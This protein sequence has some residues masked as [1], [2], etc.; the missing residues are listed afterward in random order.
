MDK[1][2]EK[3]RKLREDKDRLILKNYELAQG[4]G[5]YRE[6]FRNLV[7]SSQGLL[8]ALQ[9][10][11]NIV[12]SEPVDDDAAGKIRDI[13]YRRLFSSFDEEESDNDHQSTQS[14]ISDLC[15][16]IW[17][18]FKKAEDDQAAERGKDYFSNEDGEIDYYMGKYVA[19][20]KIVESD[21]F[22]KLEG[23]LEKEESNGSV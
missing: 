13:C 5:V 14:A 9:D 23:L 4:L 10:I 16:Y 20:K 19:M 6:L 2:G 7:N 22:K 17:K 12:N 3:I 21:K 8:T 11:V 18:E 1:A 15:D